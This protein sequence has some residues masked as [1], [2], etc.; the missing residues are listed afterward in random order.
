MGTLTLKPKV[1]ETILTDTVIDDGPESFGDQK[2]PEWDAKK[3]FAQVC[4][5]E[6]GAY[7]VQGGW[8]FNRAHQAVRPTPIDQMY[9]PQ[10]KKISR[11]EAEAARQAAQ[12]IKKTGKF[13][14]AEPES[15]VQARREDMRA[16]RAEDQ[17]A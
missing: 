15:I 8:Y 1:P 12:V 13:V 11:A 16:R 7:Y 2:A 17:A 6:G 9:N 3:P 10:P 14:P 4:G 5:V